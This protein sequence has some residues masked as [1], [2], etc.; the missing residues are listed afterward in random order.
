MRE[1]IR[2]I[3]VTPVPH[4]AAHVKG[5]INL[6]GQVIPVTDLRSRFGMAPVERSERTCIIVVE[7]VRGPRVAKAGLLVDSVCDVVD[8]SDEEVEPCAAP[9]RLGSGRIHSRHRS[10][11]RPPCRQNHPESAQPRL[12]KSTA[13][14]RPSFNSHGGSMTLTLGKRIA[15]GFVAAVSITATLGLLAY[16]RIQVI[17]GDSERVTTDALPSVATSARLE[18]SLRESHA[19]LL[20]HLITDDDARRQKLEQ[21]MD[22]LAR[23]RTA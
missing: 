16:S 18:S 12:G 3:H 13:R 9:R 6:R 17:A 4:A 19:L 20:Q 10:Q 8:I 11:C 1:I 15:L 22:A 23:L 21:E 14:R 7:I 5:V 2:Y